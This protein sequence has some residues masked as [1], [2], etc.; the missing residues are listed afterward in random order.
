MTPEEHARLEAL[1][2]RR[3]EY[4]T[5]LHALDA[6]LLRIEVCM[7]DGNFAVP[8][9]KRDMAVIRMRRHDLKAAQIA[10]KAEIRALTR[11]RAEVAALEEGLNPGAPH[12]LISHASAVLHRLTQEDVALDPAERGILNAPDAY[13]ARHGK[14]AA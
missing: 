14:K 8:A 9:A 4:A 1:T 2:T 7:N 10:V 13:L 12:S 5:K 3:M 11:K 6:E